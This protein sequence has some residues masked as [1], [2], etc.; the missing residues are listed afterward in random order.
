M[1]KIDV[2]CSEK[3][4]DLDYVG[5]GHV[6]HQ[7]DIYL[8]KVEKESY[9]VAIHI[10]G[11]AWFS[12]NSKGMADLGTIVNALLDA[13][14]A[15]VTPNHRSSMDAKFPAQIHDIKA[16]VRYVRA[17]AEKYKFDT[18][19]IVTSGFSSG[20]HLASLAATSCGVAELEGALGAYTGYSSLVDAACCWSGPTDLHYM[21]CGTEE[22]TWNHGPEEAVMGFSFKGNEEPFKALNATT[23]IDPSDPPVVVFHG[24]ADNVV[25]HCQGVHF[26]ELLSKAGVMTEFHSV[27]GG[28]HGMGMYAP[29]NLEAMVTFLEKARIAKAVKEDFVPSASNQPGKQYP[30][31]N[32]ERIVR[33][34][35]NAPDAVTVKLDIGGVKYP[36]KR[37][38][39][40]VWTGDSAP[41]DEG[42]HYYQ[43]EVD[44]ASVPDPGTLYYY[45]ASRWGSG[46]EVPAHD[47]DFYALKNVP[48]GDI[49][50][51]HYWSQT[52]NQMRH[53]FI[54]TPPGYDKNRKKRYP[55]LYLQHGGGENEYGWPEQGKTGLIMDNLIAEGKAEEFIIVMD[56]GT[57]ARPRPAAGQMPARPQGQRGQGMGLPSNW[58]DGFMNT[59]INDIIP[60]VD[61]R[62][63]T[64][65]DRK[66]RAMAGLSMGGMQTKAITMKNPDVFSALGIF[67]GG[68]ITA[69]EA[70]QT[71][72]FKEAYK[73]VFLSYGSRELENPRYGGNQKEIID[74]LK[75]SGVNAHFYVS[76]ETAHEWQSWRRSLYQFAQL[77]FK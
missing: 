34:Q 63:R 77:L 49:R 54:Y 8:P 58:A 73:L 38:A 65:A 24:T 6:G 72:G 26:H 2:H 76:P 69:E 74:E 9:P 67:S 40:G 36:M 53:C 15:V 55:V 19:F 32:S 75:A 60:M 47:Q 70:A 11:S 62:Y 71:E 45:G 59:L 3:F 39:E 16:V 21:S 66:H 52:N 20:A 61:S 44:G 29:E 68:I 17:N 57:W 22:D 51:V 12:N 42:F 41:Q 46:I 25:P 31:V 37:N 28:G 35:L 50:E 27:D 23:Y 7:M 14:Y 30:M 4:A 64:I 43:F 33:A 13:G 18:D 10:Y 48:H 1:P 5:D 56:N